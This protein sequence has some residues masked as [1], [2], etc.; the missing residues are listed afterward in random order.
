MTQFQSTLV[1]SCE[2]QRVT[3]DPSISGCRPKQRQTT[4]FRQG[5]DQSAT[6]K[7]QPGPF[8]PHDGNDLISNNSGLHPCALGAVL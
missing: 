1:L 3:A 7:E 2:L 5:G 6:P 8:D 4:I